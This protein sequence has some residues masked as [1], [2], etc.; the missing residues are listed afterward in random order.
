M[1]I[2]LV[3]AIG[4]IFYFIIPFIVI[5]FVRNKRVSNGI[6]LILFIL[7]LAV[8]FVG[9]YFRVDFVDNKVYAIP[10]FSGEWFNKT[11][12]FSFKNISKFDIVINLVMLIPV[13]IVCRY[14]TNRKNTL[15]RVLILLCV[16]FISG[17]LTEL[18]QFILPIPRGVQLSDSLFN[19]ASVLIGGC[20]G[21]V[22]YAV[23]NIIFKRR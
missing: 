19:M 13:G 5:V 7:F 1:N 3:L 21:S 16:A 18:G 17:V 20:V 12:S 11:I 23:K 2:Y 8:L 9:I 14:L 6:M 4:L 10:N 15:K 22:Y